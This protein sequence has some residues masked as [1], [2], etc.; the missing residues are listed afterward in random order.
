MKPPDSYTYISERWGSRRWLDHCVSTESAHGLISNMRVQYNLSAS[1][2][3]P[4]GLDL[5]LNINVGYSSN[6]AM[7]REPKVRWDKL[8]N[9]EINLYNVYS[10]TLLNEIHVPVETLNC[11]NFDCNNPTH[12]FEQTVFYESIINAMTT[13]S[14]PLAQEHVRGPRREIPGW[15]EHVKQSH[16][17]SINATQD[18]RDAGFPTVGPLYE[19]KVIRHKEY[20]LVLRKAKRNE[21]F[22]LGRKLAHNLTANNGRDFWKDV[23]KISGK[24]RATPTSINGI[25][26]DTEIC[27]LW[28][29]H[30]SSILNS[31]PVQNYPINNITFDASAIVTADEVHKAIISINKTNSPGPDGLLPE[32][33][34]LGPSSLCE[35][36]AKCFTSFFVHGSMPSNL[37][38]VHIVPIVK[39]Y[40]G[41]LSCLDNYRP[42]AIANC[43]SKLVE[44]CTLNRI[45]EKNQSYIQPIWFKKRCWH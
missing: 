13:T 21:K 8:S 20:K 25:S 5:N 7:D 14:L 32:H 16:S 6:I 19:N 17:N 34:K 30:Y 28:R 10:N 4:L 22:I 38:D 24:G 2:H 15:N 27:K 41:K 33:F 44:Y 26:G 39:D 37:M 3:I 9:E 31:L 45:E 29:E 36:L 23:R 42:I 40:R 12:I 11:R 35:M 43:T 1:D 18:W